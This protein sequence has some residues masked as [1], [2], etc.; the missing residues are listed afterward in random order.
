MSAT[1][2]YRVDFPKMR[3]AVDS[4]GGLI[5]KLQG[6]GDYEG[7]KQFMAKRGVLSSTVTG[8]LARLG[9]KRIRWTW[10]STRP[11]RARTEAVAHA[12]WEPPTEQIIEQP[13]PKRWPF[14]VLLLAVLGWRLGSLDDLAALACRA[15]RRR[16]ADRADDVRSEPAVPAIR[17]R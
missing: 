12:R 14:V 13:K 1:G 16:P 7:V 10:C 15:S 17:C 11:G 9:G 3:S 6:D 5:L 2:R 8:D 4:L